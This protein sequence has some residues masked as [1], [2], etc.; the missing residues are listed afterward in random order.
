MYKSSFTEK[1]VP[2]YPYRN[3][4]TKYKKVIGKSGGL[5]LVPNTGNSD[6]IYHSGEDKTGFCGSTL[7]FPLIDGT[8]AK[9]VGPWHSNSDGLFNDTGI[10]LR[11]NSWTFG[12]I[13]FTREYDVQNLSGIMTSIM[14]LDKEWT[15]GSFDRITDMAK[16]LALENKR[17]Y[18]Y[19]SA[20]SGGASSG[21]IEWRAE[22]MKEMMTMFKEIQPC[23]SDSDLFKK[24]S[25]LIKKYEHYC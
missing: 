9:I 23:V 20:S 8:V 11:E 16:K 5:W 12:C 6:S 21:M 15:K 7:E 22:A 4:P 19:Y 18:Y 10:D 24:F 17:D 1:D 13:S 3:V 14:H 25:A 2:K